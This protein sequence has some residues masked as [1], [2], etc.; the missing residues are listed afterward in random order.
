ML[1]GEVAA[2]P[3]ESAKVETGGG[4]SSPA[5]ATNFLSHA[6][7][8]AAPHSDSLQFEELIK[9]CA[10]PQWHPDPSENVFLNSES[11]SHGAE[12]FRTLRSRLY[13]LRGNQPLQTILVTSSL[14]AEGKT[15]LANN[16]AQSFVRKQDCRV[17]L[18]DADL[19]RSRLHVPLGAPVTPGLT[20]Y[21]RGTSA[22][23][24]VIQH[25]Q[26]GSLCL[27]SG[28]S[29]V[30]DPSEL[31]SSGRLKILI[32]RMKHVF[33]WIIVD[34]PPCLPVADS[35]GLADL[36]DGVLLVV[37]AASTPAEVAQKTC[38]EMQTKNLLGVVLNA[39]EKKHSSSN[40]YG[41]YGYSH[42]KDSSK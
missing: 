37:R 22:E 9:H 39:V 38:K 6:S 31:L 40:Y 18:I 35:S 27:I 30:A 34:S 11:G 24:A 12:Q 3:S 4:D 33:D 32:D 29:Q 10:H 42:D 13:Q 16:L 23:T 7:V 36:C 2:L 41:E 21:L 17:L 28:G 15:F 1:Q 5:A 8:L 14:P 25:G 19:R 20:D 26:K